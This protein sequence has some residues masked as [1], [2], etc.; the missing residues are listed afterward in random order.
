MGGRWY[1]YNETLD[2]Y[3]DI[4]SDSLTNI[5]ADLKEIFQAYKWSFND[6]IHIV[7]DQDTTIDESKVLK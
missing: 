6:V 3:Y 1:F 2:E 5:G 4:G 7:N